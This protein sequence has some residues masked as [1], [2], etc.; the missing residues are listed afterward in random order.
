MKIIVVLGGSTDRRATFIK[1]L[2]QGQTGLIQHIDIQ[3][4]SGVGGAGVRSL[5]VYFEKPIHHE[6][7]TVVS[8]ITNVAE[9]DY[10]R[11][12]KALVCHCYGALS[13]LYDGAVRIEKEDHQVLPEP[14]YCCVAD[15]VLTPP[16]ILSEV[17]INAL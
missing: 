5:Q 14:L 4:L 12:K 7:I 9:L 16:E 10:L 13:S 17:Y 6:V 1:Q 11:E 8:G 15:H 2:I 3:S